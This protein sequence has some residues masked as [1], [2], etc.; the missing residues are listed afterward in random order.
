MGYR[1]SRGRRELSGGGVKSLSLDS[2][3]DFP[4]GTSWAEERLT[5]NFSNFLRP[6]SI[7][8]VKNLLTRRVNEPDMTSAKANSLSFERMREKDE[9]DR[10]ARMNTGQKRGTPVV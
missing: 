2:R 10:V 1:P 4:V 7:K 5:I 6:I 8:R 9:Q 3:K